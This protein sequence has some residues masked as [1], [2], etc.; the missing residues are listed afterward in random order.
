MLSI[1]DFR[2][3]FIVYG[4]SLVFI[5]VLPNICNGKTK[6]LGT[7]P[8]YIWKLH[9]FVPLLAATGSTKLA[10]GGRFSFGFLPRSQHVGREHGK[11]KICN[12]KDKGLALQRLKKTK[13]VLFFIFPLELFSLHFPFGAFQF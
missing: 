6:G 2:S 4:H 5:L 3:A 10:Q 9:P 11:A 12:G 7:L 1:A 13:T 8:V